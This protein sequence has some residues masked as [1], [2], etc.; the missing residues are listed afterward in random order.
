MF[1][2]DRQKNYKLLWNDMILIKTMSRKAEFSLQTTQANLDKLKT[3]LNINQSFILS[4]LF[5]SL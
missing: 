4:H 5:S 2:A 3:R 1:K